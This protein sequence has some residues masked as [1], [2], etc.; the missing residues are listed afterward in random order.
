MSGPPRARGDQRLVFG[1]VAGRAR[2][3]SPTG[4]AKPGRRPVAGAAT[5]SNEEHDHHDGGDSRDQAQPEDR[6]VV[7]RPEGEQQEGEAGSDNGA[8]L[9]HGAVEAE[10]AAEVPTMAGVGHDGVAR[11]R[12]DPLAHPIDETDAEHVPPGSGQRQAY[13]AEGRDAVS[14]PHERL[15]T[16][17]AVAVPA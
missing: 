1:P 17:D 9:V 7:T 4:R 16:A 6:A 15:A 5:F 11:C 2:H 3:S 13:A 14:G 12:A 10:I 8:Q